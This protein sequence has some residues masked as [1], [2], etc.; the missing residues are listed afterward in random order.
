MDTTNTHPCFIGHQVCVYHRLHFHH[1]SWSAKLMIAILSKQSTAYTSA[2]SIGQNP[3]CTLETCS[4]MHIPYLSVSAA[5][6]I[7]CWCCLKGW[8]GV[9]LF[10]PPPNIAGVTVCLIKKHM[11]ATNSQH[12][13][14]CMKHYCSLLAYTYSRL[15]NCMHIIMYSHMHIRVVYTYTHAAIMFHFALSPDIHLLSV[16]YMPCSF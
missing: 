11:V 12:D 5:N 6:C 3:I 15:K 2:S 4:F 10:S 14:Q 16:S 9:A 7:S 1:N 13:H 8:R